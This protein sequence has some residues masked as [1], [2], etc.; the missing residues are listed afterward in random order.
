MAVRPYR[1]G[2]RI[3]VRDRADD[4]R[5]LAVLQASV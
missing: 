2:I 3:T 5:L 4:D 1:D